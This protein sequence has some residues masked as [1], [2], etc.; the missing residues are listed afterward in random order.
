[1]VLAALGDA[2]SQSPLHRRS[3]LLWTALPEGKAGQ[4]PTTLAG[5]RP[6]RGPPTQSRQPEWSDHTCTC[7]AVPR[8]GHAGVIVG[9]AE[10]K[11][12]LDE[13]DAGRAILELHCPN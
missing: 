8:T 5:I 11:A 2:Q 12:I 13:A 1:M 6:R 4:G 7:S 9:F 3:G 10:R